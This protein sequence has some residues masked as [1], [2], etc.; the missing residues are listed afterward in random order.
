[1]TSLKPFIDH[2]TRL[3]PLNDE[4]T[5]FMTERLMVKSFDKRS[6]ILESGA[7]SNE[8]YFILKGC[9]RM[10]YHVDGEEKT[11]FFFVE[12]QFVSS[13]ESFVKE[14]P[15]RHSLA[16]VDPTDLVV[17]TKES[18][19][20]ML[21]FSKNFDTLARIMMEE[22]LGIYQNIVASFITLSPEERYLD[23]IKNRPDLIQRIPQYQ[24][25]TYLGVN[26]E[27]LSRIRKRIASKA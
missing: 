26:A 23:L 8:F 25:A 13:Y 11:T 12:N 9:V 21:S 7:I 22:E 17:I 19:F 27:S 6:I 3:L 24:L 14:V 18:A 10:F 16:C 4:E 1:M 20:E 5:N 2:L 15:A